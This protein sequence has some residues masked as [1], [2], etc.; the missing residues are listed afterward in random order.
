MFYK[1]NCCNQGKKDVDVHYSIKLYMKCELINVHVLFL[2]FREVGGA[3][4]L[5]DQNTTLFAFTLLVH[6]LQELITSLK[7]F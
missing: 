7:D 6:A 3:S 4:F 2:C 5:R 1:S